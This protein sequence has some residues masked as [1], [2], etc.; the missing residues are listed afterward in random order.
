MLLVS[1]EGVIDN[2]DSTTIRNYIMLDTTFLIS[3]TLLDTLREV[4]ILMA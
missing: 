2:S 4:D 1:I 3:L